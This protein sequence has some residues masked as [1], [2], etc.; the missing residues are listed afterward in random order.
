MTRAI[1]TVHLGAKASRWRDQVKRKKTD[2]KRAVIRGFQPRPPTARIIV[3]KK[4]NPGHT[5]R[6]TDVQTD[7]FLIALK[8]NTLKNLPVKSP[9]F[10]Q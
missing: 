6:S 9:Q 7:V 5:S 3:S 8:Q 10:P 4:L 2:T 1:W